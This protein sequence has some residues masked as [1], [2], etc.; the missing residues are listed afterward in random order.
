[1]I[2]VCKY[3]LVIVVDVSF[4]F[5]CIGK[6]GIGVNNVVEMTRNYVVSALFLT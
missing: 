2:V 4:V 3:L 5:D 1:M 6:C